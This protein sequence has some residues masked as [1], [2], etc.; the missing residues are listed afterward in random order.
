M[1]MVERFNSGQ[2][3]VDGQIESPIFTLPND[4]PFVKVRLNMHRVD[5]AAEGLFVRVTM[6]AE[7]NAEWVE[8]AYIQMDSY[9]AAGLTN[10]H[11]VSNP[12]QY[13]RFRCGDLMG[14]NL[15][16]IAI[17][18]GARVRVIASAIDESDWTT[19]RDIG[20]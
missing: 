9:G 8:K 19:D 3:T 15:K 17:G 20:A 18:N 6:Y 12:D 1:A 5:K 13:I 2:I 11:G 14:K 16:A 10:K 7:E 4:K